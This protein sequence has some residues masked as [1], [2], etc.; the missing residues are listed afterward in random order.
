MGA[1]GLRSVTED[2]LIPIMY[3]VPSDSCIT[4]VKITKECI[5]ENAE[6]ILVRDEQRKSAQIDK[7]KSTKP[8]KKNAG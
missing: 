1:R 8:N 7:V 6:P 4:E 2:L 5:T 3:K